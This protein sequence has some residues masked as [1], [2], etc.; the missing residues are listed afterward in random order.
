MEEPKVSLTLVRA[1]DDPEVSSPEFQKAL[2]DFRQELDDHGIKVSSRWFTMDA[3]GA[4][5][6]GTGEF[7]LL[8]STLGPLAIVQLR[9]GIEAFLKYKAGRKLK[10]KIGNVTIE[11]TASEV[12]KLVTPEQIATMLESAE[13][14][15]VKRLHD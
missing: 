10:I 12:E 4:G 15:S 7:T 14:S 13:K 11:G 9:K 5:G 3:P 8:V 1:T 2:R 6:W